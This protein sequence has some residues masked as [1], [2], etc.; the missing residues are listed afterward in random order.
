MRLRGRSLVFPVAVASVHLAIY[1]IGTDLIENLHRSLNDPLGM[2]PSPAAYTA[3]LMLMATFALSPPVM[4][5]L[6]YRS[7]VLDRYLLR[8]FLPPLALC[9]G[10]ITAIMISM[11]LLNNL[12]DYTAAGHGPGHLIL[13]YV[14]LMPV[15]LVDVTEA[16]LL[17]ATLFSL[18]KMSRHNEL[19]AMHSA[20]R[21]V[22]RVLMPLLVCGLWVSVAV[23]AMN[24]QFAPDAVRIRD[25]TRAGGGGAARPPSVFNIL[26]RNREALR[27][28]YLH[29]VPYDLRADNPMSEVY[30]WQQNAG[31]DITQCWF[32]RRALWLPES[33]VWQFQHVVEYTFAD[34]ATGKPLARP[35]RTPLPFIEQ[36][37]WPETPGGML[38]DKLDPN[39]LGVPGLLSALKS[40]ASLPDKITAR[41]E[42][43]L[44]W[45][46]ALPLRCF[47]I[48]LLAAPLGIAASRR[49][50]LGGVAA[51]LGIYITVFFLSNLLLKAGEGAYLPPL[52]AAWSVNFLFAAAGIVLFW[53]RSRNRLALPLTP[54]RWGRPGK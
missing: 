23:L 19:T 3:K 5:W 27:T 11:D 21:S 17:L 10:G 53:Y 32:A 37:L 42:T 51:A 20:G 33:G 18:G 4:L 36:K 54:L 26:Y 24:F 50:A 49:N 1:W 13:Y 35:R 34:P 43:V 22:L 46:F 41:Y 38:S 15:M 2:E 45:R 7:T 48:V 16:A 28:W 12:T 8:N 40:R 31:G 14:S 44:Q 47:L 25:Q 30:V 52:L 9:L 39:Y 6:Y 29:S